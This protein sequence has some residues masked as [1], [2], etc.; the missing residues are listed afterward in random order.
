[1]AIAYVELPDGWGPSRVILVAWKRAGYDVSK[2]MCE[3]LSPNLLLL[4][5]KRPRW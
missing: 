2:L 1:M 3:P 5:G 4:N